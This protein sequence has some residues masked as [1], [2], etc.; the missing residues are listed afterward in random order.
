VIHALLRESGGGAKIC[1][2]DG[3]MHFSL[4]AVIIFAMKA[5]SSINERRVICEHTHFLLDALPAD[6]CMLG[7][8]ASRVQAERRD[9]SSDGLIFLETATL[10]HGFFC[11]RRLTKS[12]CAER[13][14]FFALNNLFCPTD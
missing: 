7:Q 1:A 8:P 4:R 12:L 14:L 6:N 11:V 9:W 5:Q 3:L 10:R 2:A 13:I